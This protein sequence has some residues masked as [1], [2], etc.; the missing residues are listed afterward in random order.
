MTKKKVTE[1]K[2]WR[3]T[4]GVKLKSTTK[5]FYIE[6]KFESEEYAARI[7]SYVGEA[8]DKHGE[9]VGYCVPL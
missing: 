4:K 5:K 9:F 1:Q 2:D 3:T 8:I 7:G 6:Q